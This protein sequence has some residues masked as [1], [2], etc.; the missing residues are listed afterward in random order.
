[1]T[2]TR[3]TQDLA[4]EGGAV[5]QAVESFFNQGGTFGML[6]GIDKPQLE[7]LYALGYAHYQ[8]GR[9]KEA[10]SLFQGVA[11]FDHFDARAFLGMG[12]A[13]QA[14]GDYQ[15]ALHNYSFGALMAMDDPRFPF[16]AAECHHRLGDRATARDAFQMAIELAGAN[17]AH[18]D[19]TTRA[20]GWIET[21]ETQEG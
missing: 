18:A 7:A 2:M 13:R 20:R 6:H 17:D 19:L 3:T 14:L 1:M 9:F 11:L 15:E 12:G 10:L 21:L 5:E 4:Q 16:H 8:S